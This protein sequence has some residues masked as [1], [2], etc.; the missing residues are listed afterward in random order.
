MKRRAVTLTL[1]LK[2]RVLRDL[3]E[4][5]LTKTQVARRNGISPTSVSRILSN[6]GELEAL[7]HQQHRKITRRRKSKRRGKDSVPQYEDP[8][9]S[10]EKALKQLQ[11]YT[12]QL[13]ATDLLVHLDGV[14]VPGGEHL[15]DGVYELYHELMQE[16]FSLLKNGVIS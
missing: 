12:V 9:A 10:F 5:Q 11:E 13:L 15:F 2:L 1:D 4:T 8:E 16:E 14:L 7:R 3:E 6:R